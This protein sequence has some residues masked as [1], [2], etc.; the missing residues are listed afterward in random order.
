MS[1]NLAAAGLVMVVILPV[2]A[3]NSEIMRARIEV[4]PEFT[5][6]FVYLTFTTLWANSA[7]DKLILFI[8][9]P[10]NRI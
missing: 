2:Y 3:L 9:F 6:N 7:G 10:E 4:I 8:F 1:G 5:Y